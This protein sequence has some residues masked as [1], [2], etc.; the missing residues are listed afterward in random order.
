MK[1]QRFQLQDSNQI[2]QQK[3]NQTHR[4]GGRDRTR[5]QRDASWYR[6][7]FRTGRDC[8][9]RRPSRAP[10]CGP[11]RS[12]PGNR[13]ECWTSLLRIRTSFS[14]SIETEIEVEVDVERRGW[15]VSYGSTKIEN[16]DQIRGE[17]RSVFKI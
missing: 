7:A 2:R 6:P 16:A 12:P 4:F 10:P 3:N 9:N 8:C 11:S 14:T 15:E 17:D 13:R 5:W 1:T